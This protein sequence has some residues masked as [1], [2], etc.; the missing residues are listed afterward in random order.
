VT[1]ERSDSMVTTLSFLSVT[2]AGLAAFLW[3]WSSMVNLPVLGSGWGTLVNSKEFYAAMRKIGR[4]NMS[5]AASAFVSAA[6]QAV[7]MYVA[8]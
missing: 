6:C 2:F 8:I 3:A 7:A 5:A 1:A 4:L